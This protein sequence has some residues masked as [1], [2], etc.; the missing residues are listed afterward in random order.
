MRFPGQWKHLGGL[1]VSPYTC[2]F[3]AMWLQ[4]RATVRITDRSGQVFETITD[5]AM[6]NATNVSETNPQLASH[7]RRRKFSIPRW[8]PSSWLPGSDIVI[9][10]EKIGG[11]EFG[12]KHLQSGVIDPIGFTHAVPF[13]LVQRV[14]VDL[15]RIKRLHLGEKAP[16]PREIGRIFLGRIPEAQEF[17]VI[18]VAAQ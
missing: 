17:E 16:D 3:G 4:I 14:D 9:A 13:A 18:R 6:N 7:I 2:D 10:A 5:K 1:R 11:I 15:A 8:G 12:F